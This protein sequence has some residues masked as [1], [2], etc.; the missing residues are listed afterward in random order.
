MSVKAW[1]LL[2][3]PVGTSCWSRA[4]EAVLRW[5]KI[6]PCAT[7]NRSAGPRQV[8]EGRSDLVW[9]IQPPSAKGRAELAAPPSPPL[10]SPSPGQVLLRG[11]SPTSIP[12]GMAL[13]RTLRG[14][15]CLYSSLSRLRGFWHRAEEGRRLPA[16]PTWLCAPCNRLGHISSP[17][18]VA[19]HGKACGFHQALLAGKWVGLSALG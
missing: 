14:A 11:N 5:G 9:Q 1:Q 3:A 12:Q 18:G 4:A 6:Q 17:E 2:R 10:C 15:D 13:H 19:S 7:W 8:A 16:S